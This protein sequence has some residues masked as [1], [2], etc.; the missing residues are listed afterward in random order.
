M[1]GKRK[2]RSEEDA[3]REYEQRMREGGPAEKPRPQPT[4][5]DVVGPLGAPAEP[6]STRP[7]NYGSLRDFQKKTGSRRKL[8]GKTRRRAR[9]GGK[10]TSS[11]T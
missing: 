10:Q 9:R 4:R 7:K 8:T 1:E 11:R 2:P 6:V 5:Q 3:L